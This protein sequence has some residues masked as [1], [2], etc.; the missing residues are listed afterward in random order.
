MGR[1]IPRHVDTL[2]SLEMRNSSR[3][4]S[5]QCAPFLRHRRLKPAGFTHWS[6]LQRVC[7]RYPSG[8]LLYWQTEA[9]FPKQPGELAVSC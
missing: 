8:H 4:D 1:R 3:S 5:D 2:V 6:R 7:V 9:E